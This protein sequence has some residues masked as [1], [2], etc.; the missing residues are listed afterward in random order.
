MKDICHD[1]LAEYR[2]LAA[3]CET[4]TP[5][6]WQER[7]EFYGWTPWDEIAHLC[8][9]DETGLQSA[10]EPAGPPPGRIPEGAA[11]RHPSAPE[12]FARDA[13]VLSQRM[14]RG[15]EISAVARAK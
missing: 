5:Q 9:F 7:S 8:Y 4:L 6:Q 13:A 3:L 2:D 1:L 10:H 11:R 15:E 14:E 12:A